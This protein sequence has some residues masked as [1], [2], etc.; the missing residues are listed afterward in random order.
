LGRD[1]V[2]VFIKVQQFG[3]EIFDGLPFRQSIAVDFQF[4]ENGQPLPAVILQS[5]IC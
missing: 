5:M 3:L 4:R 1:A 2:Q